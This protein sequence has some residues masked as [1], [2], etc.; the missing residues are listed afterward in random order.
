MSTPPL[1]KKYFM[2]YFK[3]SFIILFTCFLLVGCKSDKKDTPSWGSLR[4]PS[5]VYT[6][7]DTTRIQ[8]LVNEYVEAFRKQDFE[9]TAD[10]LYKVKND[11]VFPLTDTEKKS[12]IKAMSLLPVYGVKEYAFILR[13]DKNNEVRLAVQM[14]SSGDI[15]KGIGVTY[16]SLN[17]V[18]KDGEWYLTM[19]DEKAEG[20]DIHAN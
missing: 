6:A 3:F 19:L 18:V 10:M 2:N 4:P 15:D 9:T 14:I 16:V 12:Y 1:F 20:V 17:P 8:E 5:M 11:S 13:S 7:Q